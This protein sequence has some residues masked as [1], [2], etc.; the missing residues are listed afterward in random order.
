MMVM[1]AFSS[2]AA[3]YLVGNEPFGN[4]WDPSSGVELTM[5]SDGTYSFTATINGSIWFVF[6]DGLAEAGD[7]ST[8]NDNLRI[9]P[10]GGDETVPVGEWMTTQ[11]SGGDHGAYKFT[12]SGGEY[13]VT[14]NPYINKF[15]IDGYVAPFV[16]TSCTVAGTPASIF[17]TE[18]DNT[19]TANDMTK[20]D[21]GTYELKK[22]G[23]ELAAGEEIAFKVVGN[24][25]WGNAWP[26]DNYV[27]PIEES[28]LYDLRF[29]FNPENYEVGLEVTPAG[30]FDPI[31]GNLFILGEVNGNAWDPS[32]GLEMNADDEEGNIF[33]ATFTTDGANIDANDGIGYSYFSFTTKLSDSAEDW[34]SISGYR[35]GAIENDYL[36]SDDMMGIE[37]GLSNFGQ[38]NS[39]KI[40]AGEYEVTVN[41]NAKTM[42][43]NKVEP[44]PEVYKIEKM[45][46]IDDLSSMYLTGVRQGFGMNGK[47]YINDTQWNGEGEPSIYVYDEN[48]LV[49]TIPGAANTPITRDEAGNLIITTNVVFPSADWATDAAGIKVINPETGEAKEYAIPEECGILGRCDFFGF[50]KGNLMED[51][52]LYLTGGTNSGISILTIAGGEVSADECYVAPCD[53]LSPTTST[54]INYYKD[55]AGE[56]A[57]LY[58]TR[59]AAPVKITFDGDNL[60]PAAISVPGKGACNGMFPLIWDGK[61]YFVYP[62]LPNYQNGFA[63][64]EAGAEAPIVEVPS[65]VAANANGYQA[66]WL[67]AEIDEFGVV[68]IYQYYPGG[69]MTV[70]RL[71]SANIPEPEQTEAPV[72]TSEV[73][74][75]GVIIT[76]TG[77]GEVHLYVNGEEVENPYTIARGEE[78]VT[79]VV[80]ATAKAEGK[81][82]SETT[83]LEVVVPAKE[84]TPEEGYK[85]EK[86]WSIDDLSSMYL[87]GVRQG[88]GMNGKFYIND[89]QW[90]GE[91]EPS[92]YVYDENGLVNTIPGA[93]NTP[94]TRDEAGNLIIT[95]NVVFPSADWA[96]DAAG[97]KV[98]N[99]ETGEAKEYAIPEECGILGRCDFFGFAKGNLMEDG[100][101]Y[102]TGGTNSG[103]SILTIAGGEVSADECYVA[104]CD[105]L[106]PTTS[107]VINYY[108]DL[109]G[110]DALLYVTRNAAPVKITF[111]GDNLV[112]AAISVPGKGACNGMFPLIW[113]GK[114]YFVYPTLPNYQNGFAVGEAGAEAPIVEVPSSV[115]A[116]ANG[117]QANWLNA[118]IDENGVTIYQY[119]PGG[120]MTVYRL[121]KNEGGVEEIINNTDK[122]VSSVRY[123]NIMG[124]EMKEANGITIV[125]TT[126]TDG[127]HSAIKVIK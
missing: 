33:S 8:F 96:T 15:K 61:E 77:E 69:N 37:V 70:Y 58:V 86:L 43:I 95:T 11:K 51:G 6:A 121:T 114:E 48:G 50:A 110:E 31:T 74:E 24:Y 35:I 82:I 90:N 40:P 113:D 1:L 38:S 41:L 107:T 62:T 97:I 39:F 108:K 26:N 94:I 118:E 127:T 85:I 106:S 53:G 83:T 124:Q 17:G 45:W 89:T 125:V 67:N 103:I 66:N 120:N 23:C 10:T 101:L 64:G 36:L 34:G 126:Y 79:V 7:W 81:L 27:Y 57:L 109:A 46:S 12:G 112:P 4:G 80:T 104:P 19:N 98:I 87:T 5:N 22:Y 72:I 9:G 122:V 93:A 49:N 68:T 88:F 55:L 63:V 119:Y 25:D 20:L 44:V 30:S 65:S 13:V 47:F 92:I 105:G 71:T 73:T 102:L 123:Y 21:D 116:N 29:T 3:Y 78:D 91:G 100:V 115:A 32:I 54:V 117:Y 16:L 52:V 76:A 111:D 99:P 60:V 28:G 42:V 59:N 56:D 14:Y 84:I 2:Q 18:W 75:D